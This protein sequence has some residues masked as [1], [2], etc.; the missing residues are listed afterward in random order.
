MT[1]QLTKA[2]LSTF[3]ENAAV[4][5]QLTLSTDSTLTPFVFA[6]TALLWLI[7]PHVNHPL[8]SILGL[9]TPFIL[10]TAYTPA[11]SGGFKLTLQRS[12]AVTCGADPLTSW[13]SLAT[14]D[15]SITAVSQ[16]AYEWGSGHG[17]EPLERNKA[18]VLT[19]QY[20]QILPA[21]RAEENDAA[22]PMLVFTR[23]IDELA[24]PIPSFYL[25]VFSPSSPYEFANVVALKHS[26]THAAAEPVHV[27][28]SAPGMEVGSADRSAVQKLQHWV[29]YD[30]LGSPLHPDNALGGL[31]PDLLKPDSGT[32]AGIDAD[33]GPES[34][35]SLLL[36]ASTSFVVLKGIWSSEAK[37]GGAYAV[38][39]PPA[40][41][42]SA[43][44]V[45]ELVSTPLPLDPEAASSLRS[46]YMEIKRLETWCECWTLG[47][48][49][50]EPG[51]KADADEYEFSIHPWQKPDDSRRMYGDPLAVPS[52]DDTAKTDA[53]SEE[54]MTGD[55][56][57]VDGQLQARE[58]KPGSQ[59]LLEHRE[60]FGKK[61]DEF[62]EASIYD[63]RGSTALGRLGR[64][65]DIHSVA[66][67]S[68]REDLD[69][70][71]RLWNISHYAHDDSDLSELIT[72]VAEGL[73]TRKLQPYIHHSNQSPLAQ[74]IRDAL[75]MAQQKTLIDEE[76]ESER[77]AGQ[78]DAWI[79]D[80]PLDALV[81]VGLHKLRSDFWFYFV[82]GQLAT[83]KQLEPFV[84]MAVEPAKLI[85][86]FRLL[87]RVLE[88]WSLVQQGV[89]GMPRHFA[90]QVI[91]S[92]LDHFAPALARIDDEEDEE[93][94]EDSR[95][96]GRDKESGA[97]T[98]E[99]GHGASVADTGRWHGSDMVPAYE[100]RLK[101]T[102]YL[103]MYSTEVQEFV[104]AIADGFDPARYTIATSVQ[105]A[106]CGGL[107]AVAPKRR[108]KLLT[109]TPALIDPRFAPDTDDAVVGA[110]D[111]DGSL[112][113]LSAADDDRYTL[114]EA[115]LF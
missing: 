58:Q 49:W 102:T 63:T 39:L 88:V 61:I 70:T 16:Y 71:E 50:V 12:A 3:V 25:A 44:W 73:E 11:N 95:V 36:P 38:E 37:D 68:I 22:L 107:F 8:R 112:S 42:S 81:H 15:E 91:A 32:E 54:G 86:R 64:T 1:I 72:A 85:Q 89:P 41:S 23:E 96:S 31:Q 62:I 7:P 45:L 30:L 111:M 52:N 78:L 79:D 65:K 6:K 114:F 53:A 47:S 98:G 34:I 40:P 33:T 90:C 97:G 99:A 94:N 110:I 115:K 108:V 13:S 9:S 75:Q 80:Q 28:E 19:T 100:D 106:S 17:L 82:N 60:A 10:I 66:G 51:S 20:A 35:S 74:L 56:C 29:E 109:K 2:L 46:L 27:Y 21:F 83:P 18:R 4:K 92:L 113:D 14:A 105:S 101:I 69:F 76:G 55:S 87:L 48:K 93:S 24:T 67:L 103:P 104:L 5:A 43:Q 57:M 77:L 26:G 84:D 59:R